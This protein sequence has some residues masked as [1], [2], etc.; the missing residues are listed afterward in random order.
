LFP[1]LLDHV[2]EPPEELTQVLLEHVRIHG[3]V[4]RLRAA[5]AAGAPDGYVLRELGETLRAHVR[6][7][8][9]KLFPLIESAVPQADLGAL[10]LAPRDRGAGP[11]E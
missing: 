7:E 8:E 1:V 2:V 6:L 10:S 11:S 5:V 4:A 3:M 9:N